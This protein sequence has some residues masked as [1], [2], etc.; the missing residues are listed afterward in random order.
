MRLPYQTITQQNPFLYFTV[1]NVDLSIYKNNVG[2]TQLMVYRARKRG[3]QI[4]YPFAYPYNPPTTPVY[5]TPLEVSKQQR[6]TFVMDSQLF[7]QPEGRFV[8]ALQYNG[9]WIQ[10]TEFIYSN[11]C[12]E[13]VPDQ[14]YGV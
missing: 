10:C 1:Q 5:Y 14:N 12:V 11:P 8:A 7:T 4:N 6:F 13:L 9:V 2:T 3:G